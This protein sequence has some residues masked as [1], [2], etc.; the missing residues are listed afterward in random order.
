MRYLFNILTIVQLRHAM[1][2]LVFILG[3]LALPAGGYSQMSVMN[4]VELSHITGHGFTDFSLTTANGLDV[5]RINLN[6]Q[7]ATYA[8]MDSMKIGHWDA[9]SGTGWDQDWLGVS[10][11]SESTDMILNDFILQAEF[12]NIDDPA[13]RELKSLT[14]GYQSVTGELS[15]NFSSISLLPGASRA[16]EGQATYVFDGDPFLLHINVDGVNQGV[17][18]D[19]GSAV[20]Q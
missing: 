8:T 20:K 16:N 11:G 18:L 10:M 2:A 17:W 5:A 3:L 4:D 6:M 7:A 19:F 12:T 13:A 14:I 15:G 1:W 9:G